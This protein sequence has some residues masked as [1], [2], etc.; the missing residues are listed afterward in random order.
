MSEPTFPPLFA[1]EELTGRADPFERAKAQAIAGCDPGTI[2]YNLSSEAL[3]AAIVFGPEVPLEDAMAMLPACGVGFQN[4]LGSLA[5]PE[6]AV[7]LEWDGNIRVNGARCGYLKASA[8]TQESGTEPDWL[9]IG[10]HLDLLPAG[11]SPG[12]N[13]DRTALY[14]EGCADVEAQ[15]LLLAALVEV[16]DQL[17]LV[18]PLLAAAVGALVQ[19][20]SAEDVVVP[21]LGTGGE[22]TGKGREGL[23]GQ[24]A[25]GVV[26]AGL[27]APQTVGTEPGLGA[28]ATQAVVVDAALAVAADPGVHAQR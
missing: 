6:V 10:L 16:V 11:D 19:P 8:S 18:A 15:A 5:P 13:P 23:L 22:L 17:A 2:I 25:E 4:A 9:V 27:L 12:D 24:V 26:A 21:G 1:G 3:R 7:H 20:R 14:E 28:D